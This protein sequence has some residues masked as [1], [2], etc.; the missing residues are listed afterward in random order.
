MRR[1]RPGPCGVESSRR[2]TASSPEMPEPAT[3]ALM[4]IGFGGVGWLA[5]RRRAVGA[6][7]A[8][9]GADAANQMRAVNKP[10]R[11]GNGCKRLMG[12]GDIVQHFYSVIKQHPGQAGPTTEGEPKRGPKR[13]K[14]LKPRK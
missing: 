11:L 9:A 7:A 3:W 10:R 12:A 4:L 5:S 1:W 2:S 14:T 8:Y 13:L 6:G